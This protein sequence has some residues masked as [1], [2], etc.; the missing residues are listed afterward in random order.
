MIG[1]TTPATK[2]KG[3][4]SLLTSSRCYVE[5]NIKKRMEFIT[6]AWEMSKNMFFFGMREHSFHEYLQA[7]L[8]NEE[9]FYL[10]AVVPFSFKVTNMT[11]LRRREEDLPYPIW[12]KQLNVCWKEKVKNLNIIV[13][14]CNQT[15]TR[16]EELF[17]RLTKIYIAG[18]A[19]KVQDPKL[20]F[21]SFFLTK[22]DFDEQVEIFK[23]LSF[24]NFYAILVY[25]EDDLDN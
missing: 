3:S 6:E 20:I 7:D 19:N 13:Q 16:R 25:N 11:E 2:L 24:E 5:N 1:P 21:N 18:R 22:Q 14:A 15:I 4:S 12:I 8:N 10:D 17:K 23:G 9:G